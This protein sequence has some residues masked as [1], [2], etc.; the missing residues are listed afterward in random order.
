MFAA[1][2]VLGLDNVVR[3]EGNVGGNCMLKEDFF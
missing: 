1:G 3:N 2:C